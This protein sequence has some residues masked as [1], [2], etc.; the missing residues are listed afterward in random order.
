[1]SGIILL[2]G[3]ITCAAMVVFVGG[4]VVGLVYERSIRRWY[5]SHYTRQLEAAVRRHLD[6]EA[7]LCRPR[8]GTAEALEFRRARKA[9]EKLVRWERPAVDESGLVMVRAER[10]AEEMAS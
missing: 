10:R 8:A 2:L 6:A 1:M 9:L 3:I 7:A 5:M 4:L